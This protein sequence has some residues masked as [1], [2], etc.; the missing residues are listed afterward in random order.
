MR[1]QLS[2]RFSAVA[3]KWACFWDVKALKP[4]NV[5]L[6]SPGHNMT[7]KQFL[8]S[9][10]LSANSL[11]NSNFSF[12]KKIEIAVGD[13]VKATGC[14]TNLG[15]ILLCTPI[16]QALQKFK[17]YEKEIE[18]KFFKEGKFRNL[19]QR[20]LADINLEET[21]AV[22]RAIKYAQ[23]GGLG[24]SQ[25]LDVSET[26]TQTLMVAMDF[27]KKRDFIAK[28][29]VCGFEDI[30]KQPMLESVISNY[31]ENGNKVPAFL[32][33]NFSSFVQNL[34][35]FWLAS[36][37]DTHICRK[38]GEKVSNSVMKE[39]QNLIGMENGLQN[40]VLKVKNGKL[41]TTD[42]KRLRDLDCFLKKRGINP[43][44]TAD[45]TVCTLFLIAL[46]IPGL[47]NVRN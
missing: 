39:A 18:L 33:M 41:F 13:S 46:Q 26:P 44:T 23:P 27:A 10:Q 20:V 37:E 7:A 21:E 29:Y 31:E 35:M 3:F 30:F 16:I 12:G 1:Y 15:I 2:R 9:S 6:S 17:M 19:V 11:F 38:F 8:L 45:L 32:K 4:G 24:K 40:D 34:Y 43:G 36:N 42:R 47:V 22:F 14:N 5:S 28:Q 25:K